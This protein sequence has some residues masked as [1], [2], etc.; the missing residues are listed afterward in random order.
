MI[1][2]K[3]DSDKTPGVL[4]ISRDPQKTHNSKKSVDKTSS[5]KK[6]HVEFQS[7]SWVVLYSQ[8]Y[9]ATHLHII[10]NTPKTRI[11]ELLG[12][13]ISSNW[14]LMNNYKIMIKNTKENIIYSF[15]Y[16]Y[17]QAKRIYIKENPAF[18]S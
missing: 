7:P 8:N 1:Y 10:L 11:L 3:A 14:H 4:Q 6:S 12:E 5:L 9:G 13:L 2:P 17:V 18:Q 15:K 16:K